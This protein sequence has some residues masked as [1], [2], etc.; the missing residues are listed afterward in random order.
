MGMLE[1]IISLHCLS[2]L[3]ALVIMAEDYFLDL[4]TLNYV[5][6]FI[7]NLSLLSRLNQINRHILNE[8]LISFHDGKTYDGYTI[9]Y[10]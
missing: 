4:V 8:D 10:E 1:K 2:E 6:I 9:S 3:R 5:L 7:M